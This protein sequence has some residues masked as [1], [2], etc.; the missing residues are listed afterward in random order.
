MCRVLDVSVSG[1]YAWRKRP[2]SQREEANQWLVRQIKAIHARSHKTYGSQ[3][4]WAELQSETGSAFD[5]AISL[6]SPSGVGGTK[7]LP[8]P[9]IHIR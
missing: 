6:Y 3:R 7:Q 8:N 1:Y 9:S 4:V 2:R 5:A